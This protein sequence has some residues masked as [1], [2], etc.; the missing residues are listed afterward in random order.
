MQP[1]PQRRHQLLNVY[2]LRQIVGGARFE[3]FLTIAFH[4]LG[5]QRQNRQPPIGRIRANRLNGFIAIHAR[6]HDVH[7]HDRD[8]AA[9]AQ[10]GDRLAAGRGREHFHAAPLEHAAQGKDVARVIVDQQHGASNQI[11]I[12][13]V[14][15]FQH[16]LLALRQIGDHAM[17]E[18][19]RLIQQAFGR[20]HALHHDAACHGVQLRVFVGQEFAS[21]EYHHGDIAERCIVANSLQHLESRHVGQLQVE[22]HAIYGVVAQLQQRAGARVGRHDFYIVGTQQLGDALALGFIVFHQQQPLAARLGVAFDARKGILQAFGGGRLLYERK[23]AARQTVM[24][25]LVQGDDLHRNVPGAGI[26]FELAQYRPAKHVGQEN[27]ERYGGRMVRARQRQ[28]VRTAM[29]E[30]Y[31]ESFV[32]RQIDHDARI[33]RIVLDDQNH[34]VAWREV[35]PVIDDLLDRPLGQT[36]LRQRAGGGR[37]HAFRGHGSPQRGAAKISE[38]QVQ[39]EGAARARGTAQLNF[40]AEQVREFAADRQP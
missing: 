25:I 39:R 28:R 13:A 30:Q 33:V 2:R 6:H 10:H 20:F 37:L 26:L 3:A 16:A 27:I 31:L 17:Q 18:Q 7:Q 4:G 24:A 29:R 15:A 14:Q 36:R 35:V 40:P 1:H 8:V 22:H 34:A 9:R 12:R 21:G 23:C 38:R 32:L 11:F 19:R 5:G